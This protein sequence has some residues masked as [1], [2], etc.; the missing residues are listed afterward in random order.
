MNVLNSVLREDGFVA[1]IVRDPR[2]PPDT[3]FLMGFIGRAADPPMI[4]VY[5]DVQL[6][7][8]VDLP[9]TDL[10]HAEPMPP[11]Q[12]PLGGQYLWVLRSSATMERLREAQARLAQVQQDTALNLQP[13]ATPSML[14]SYSNG[15]P[16]VSA[17]FGQT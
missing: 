7:A 17:G 6:I 8:Y 1:N 2:E 11:S 10:L 16:T 5:L 9:E 3:L 15:W 12:S 4:R 13:T 14:G